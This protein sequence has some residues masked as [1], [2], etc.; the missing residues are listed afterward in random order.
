MF[1]LVYL[2]FL[3]GCGVTCGRVARKSGFDWFCCVVCCLFVWLCFGLVLFVLVVFVP[4]WGLCLWF[5][6]LC[7]HPVVWD[8]V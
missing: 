7:W 3:L 1:N 2:F 6:V 5:V 4:N 8:A